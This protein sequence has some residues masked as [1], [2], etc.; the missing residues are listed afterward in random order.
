MITRGWFGAILMWIGALLALTG[1]WCFVGTLT[2]PLASLVLIVS[3]I[4]WFCFAS[5][6]EYKLFGFLPDEK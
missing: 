3:A 6:L 5:W 2:S 4:A 1:T